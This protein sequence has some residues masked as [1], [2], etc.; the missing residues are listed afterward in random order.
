[1]IEFL[2]HNPVYI[3]LVVV[4]IIWTGIFT[5]LFRLDSKLSRLEKALLDLNSTGT[6][7]RK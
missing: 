4:L 7:S 1:M 3:V 6:H 2:S 5:Y